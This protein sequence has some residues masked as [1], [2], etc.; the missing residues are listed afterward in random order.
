[1]IIYLRRQYDKHGF[2]KK[3]SLLEIISARSASLSLQLKGMYGIK[4]DGGCK[5]FAQATL[6]GEWERAVGQFFGSDNN[7]GN[8]K[9]KYIQ[10]G[11]QIHE[12]PQE[13]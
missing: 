6:S 11:G 1:M 7:Q 13:D 10:G 2:Q 3:N 9:Y 8:V 12:V 5:K 4:K